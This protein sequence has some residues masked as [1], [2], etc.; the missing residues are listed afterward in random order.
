MS[1]LTDRIEAVLRCS[2]AHGD[3]RHEHPRWAAAVA[4]QIEAELK[5]NQL[6]VR[7]M[8]GDTEETNAHYGDRYTDDVPAT[9]RRWVSAYEAM[10]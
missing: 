8:L 4:Q 9:Q 2:C 10:T 6:V 5:R 7:E 3:C 1:A